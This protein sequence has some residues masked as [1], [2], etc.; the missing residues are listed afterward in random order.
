MW[1][2]PQAGR[3]RDGVKGKPPFDS[4]CRKRLQ[5]RTSVLVTDAAPSELLASE[6][7][8][9]RRS[10]MEE[11]VSGKDSFCQK[12]HYYTVF[13]GWWKQTLRAGSADL[14]LIH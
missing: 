13:S 12:V 4:Q 8:R 3:P 10:L 5:Q 2:E 14:H 1:S 11:F 6:Q 9:A 7:L